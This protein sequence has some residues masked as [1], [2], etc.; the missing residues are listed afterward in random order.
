[1]EFSNSNF[2][3]GNTHTHAF[4]HIGGVLKLSISKFPEGDGFEIFAMVSKLMHELTLVELA[5]RK[6]HLILLIGV[7]EI[8]SS[9]HGNLGQERGFHSLVFCHLVEQVGSLS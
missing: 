1:L 8:N 9:L 3:I 7:V 4:T 6:R 2:E 5:E